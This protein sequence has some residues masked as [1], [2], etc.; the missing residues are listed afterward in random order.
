MRILAE[1]AAEA[2]LLHRRL[3]AIRWA[4]GPEV[5]LEAP[6][7]IGHRLPQ[8]LGTAMDAAQLEQLLR[9]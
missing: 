1:S 6:D 9:M 2:D 5:T 4:L 8:L 7:L 3:P